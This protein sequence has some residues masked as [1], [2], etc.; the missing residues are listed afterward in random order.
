MDT[1]D[2]EIC[3]N[4][5]RADIDQ[6]RDA[7]QWSIGARHWLI[8]VAFW[9]G[10]LASFSSAAHAQFP[11]EHPPEYPS[12]VR[13]NR[14]SNFV[15]GSQTTNWTAISCLVAYT[16]AA[17]TAIEAT[18][19]SVQTFIQ[20]AVTSVNTTYDNSGVYIFLTLAYSGQVSY[21]ESGNQALDLQRFAGVDDGYMD[22]I[23]CWRDWNA[24]DVCVLLFVDPTS[25]GLAEDILAAPQSAFCAVHWQCAISRYSL[26]HE[27]GHLQGEMHHDDTASTPFAYGHGF[28]R[29]TMPGRVMTVMGAD[30]FF[31]R[32]PY[33]SSPNLYVGGNPQYPMGTANWNN[34]VRVLN[35][36]AAYIAGFRNAPQE[37]ILSLDG[38]A[39]SEV[40]VANYPNPFNPATIV[41]YSVPA[42]GHVTVKI[43]NVLGQEVALLVDEYRERGNYQIEF[44]GS[45]LPSG[46]Y[47]CSVQTGAQSVIAKF[48]LLK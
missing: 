13:Y 9:F 35:E 21:T 5:C 16:P 30:Q 38:E 10:T 37:C 48:L 47:L 24:A 41:K 26:A 40:S 36:T 27:I 39:P 4:F 2:F 45:N 25:C 17:R 34:N 3:R 18:G 19:V 22:I 29:K 15:G 20:N 28:F 8:S 14:P 6:R 43:L 12:G 23:H 31:P 1:E 44:N 33:W 42:A 11:A 46:L 32:D 7:G